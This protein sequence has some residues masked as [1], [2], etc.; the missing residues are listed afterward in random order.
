MNIGSVKNYAMGVVMAGSSMLVGCKHEAPKIIKDLPKA[1][2]IKFDTTG[3]KAGYHW[4]TVNGHNAVVSDT[5]KYPINK[6]D[7]LYIPN[8]PFH[9]NPNDTVAIN[10]VTK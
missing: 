7:T 10:H 8:N 1:E 6:S 4:E 9:I 5:I 3:L 2:I